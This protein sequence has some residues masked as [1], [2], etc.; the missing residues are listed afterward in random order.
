MHTQH[1]DQET[2]N[3]ATRTKAIVSTVL[4]DGRI[5]ETVYRPDSETTAFAVW[6]GE[7]LGIASEIVLPGERLAP[8]RGDNPLLKNRV[9]LFPSEAAKVDNPSALVDEIAAYIHTYVDLTPTFEKLAVEYVLFTW[10]YDRFRELPYLRLHGEY[11]SGKTRF[12]QVVGSICRTPIFA[13]GAS[14]VSPLFHLLDRFQGTL[15]LDEADF[16]FSDERAQ[17][18]KIMNNGNVR[19]FSVLRSESVNGKEYRP[20][21][22][23]VYGPKIVAMRGEFDDRAL[24]SRFISERSDGRTLRSDIP[25]N[26][27]EEQAQEALLLRNKLLTYRFQ[28]FAEAGSWIEAIDRTLEPR[29]NQVFAPLL[30]NIDD[31]ETREALRAYARTRNRAIVEERGASVEAQL[32]AVL[33]H[34][35]EGAEFN[36]IPLRE[37]ADLYSRAF[38]ADAPTPLT[39]RYVG[40]ILRKHLGLRPQKSHGVYAIPA[41]ERTKLPYLFDR[42]NVSEDDAAHVAAFDVARALDVRFEPILPRDRVDFGDV[43]DIGRPTAG[44]V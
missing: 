43:G 16:R 2:P 14:T 38:A 18:V 8:Y 7:R 42:F 11:G 20:V 28:R 33:R 32:L 35:A 12:L 23:Q 31:P 29:L 9:V 30:A 17:L 36:A 15:V 34:L 40:S 3:G 19:G 26:L 39:P 1:H 25:L 13:G 27:P 21:P 24:E 6:D 10:V 22:Y 44:G 4:P 37:I 41:I 5:V